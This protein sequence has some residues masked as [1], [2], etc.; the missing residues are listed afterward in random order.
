MGKNLHPSIMPFVTSRIQSHT[1]VKNIEDISTAE[2][3]IYKVSR[4]KGL[5]DVIIFI[6]DAYYF[7]DFDYL[8]KPE[9][10]DNG[11][12]I[13]IAKPE[14]HFPDDS[15]T[16]Y[17]DDKIIIGKIGVLLGALRIAE[18]WTYEKPQ[19]QPVQK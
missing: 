15:Q 11:G 10:L 3:Y 8:S 1:F 17:I 13:L 6:S 19:Q 2:H 16:N 7:G 5:C 4:S 12:I 18:Y 14:A 9:E